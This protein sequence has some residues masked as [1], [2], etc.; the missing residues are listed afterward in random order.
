MHIIKDISIPVCLPHCG[1]S[2]SF[3]LNTDSPSMSDKDKLLSYSLIKRLLFLRE[4]TVPDV[5]AFVSYI[6]TRMKWPTLCHKNGHM[7]VDLLSVKKLRLFVLS[8]TKKNAYIWNHCFWNILNTSWRYVN[9]PFNLE[10][11]RKYPSQWRE[12][13]GVWPN[14]LMVTHISF[15]P[16]KILIIKNTFTLVQIKMDVN[17]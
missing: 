15:L 16:N 13:W 5:H 3:K 8:S 11:S 17:W 6:I 12:F 4:I 2:H 10:D 9:K 7:Q 1:F 14:G